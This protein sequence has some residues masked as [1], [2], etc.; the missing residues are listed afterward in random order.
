MLVRQC[1]KAHGVSCELT[2]LPCATP[3]PAGANSAQA[4]LLRQAAMRSA[5]AELMLGG[6]G[7]EMHRMPRM[8]PYTGELYSDEDDGFYEDEFYEGGFVS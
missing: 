3:P 8:D 1:S 2:S 6:Y 7:A 4:Q 5:A